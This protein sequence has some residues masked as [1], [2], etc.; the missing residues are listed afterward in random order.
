M[1]KHDLDS[2]Q[3]DEQILKNRI[4]TCNLCDKL[5]DGNICKENKD[6]IIINSIFENQ[7]CP[8]NKW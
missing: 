6:N 5:Q 1:L 3:V 7:I 8:L 2:P 4:N